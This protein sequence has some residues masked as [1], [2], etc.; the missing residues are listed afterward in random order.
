MVLTLFRRSLWSWSQWGVTYSQPAK[1]SYRIQGQYPLHHQWLI[2]YCKDWSQ[3][4][5]R[6]KQPPPSSMYSPTPRGFN[7]CTYR[8]SY[9]VRPNSGRIDPGK[10]VEVQGWLLW[11]EHIG[12]DHVVTLRNKQFC[13]RQWRRIRRQIRSAKINSLSSPLRLLEIWSSLMSHRL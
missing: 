12:L 8:Y 4:I 13:S 5:S 3:V 1:R 9:C 11:I 6:S 2:Y 7:S 10:H